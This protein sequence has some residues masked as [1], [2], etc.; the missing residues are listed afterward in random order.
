MNFWS[1]VALN[2]DRIQ[3][4]TAII[5]GGLSPKSRVKVV[6]KFWNNSLKPARIFVCLG[7]LN[8]QADGGRSEAWMLPLS[9]TGYKTSTK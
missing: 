6:D 4:K 7:L 5:D 3:G 2:A 1:I 8:K 9:Y